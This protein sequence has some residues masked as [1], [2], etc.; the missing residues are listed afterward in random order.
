MTPTTP[1]LWPIPQEL[2]PRPDS[3][4]LGECVIVLP[5][6]ADRARAA[7][8]QLLADMVLDDYNLVVPIVRG[9]APKEKMPIRIGIAG[10][11]GVATPANLPGAEGYLLSVTA[12]G[13]EATGRD[14]RGAQYAIA[15]L[16]QLMAQE[17]NDVLVRGAE[18]RDWPYK[19]VRMVHLYLPGEDH[20]PYARRYL[21]DFLIRYKYN[22]LFV[23]I[24]GGVRLPKRPEIAAG[25]RRF[26]DDLR[27][28]GDM[29]PVYG[30]HCP[31]GP[32]GRF[33]DSIHTHL[34]DGRFLQPEDLTQLASWTRSLDLDFVPE[35]Q[36]LMH[37]FYLATA[38]PDIAELKEAAFPDSY[39]PCNPK[40]YEILFDVM[41]SYIDLTGC[42][43]V[44]IGHDE[45][46]AGGL[47]PEC[48]PRDTGELYGDD[49]VKIAQWLSARGQ[50]VWMWA[51]HLI[52]RHN[53]LGGS[54]RGGKVW[55]DHPQ[56]MKAAEIIKAGAPFIT[57]LNWSHYLG[58][59]E[60]DD[61]LTD[62][63]F[64]WIFGNFHGPSFKDWPERSAVPKALGAEVS[65]WCAWEDFEL[66]MIHYPDAV[67]C[68]N[69]LWS[70]HWP[71]INEAKQL[72]ARQMP[73]LRDRMRRSWEKP[74]LWSVAVGADRKHV[75]PIA[76]AC[77]AGPKG[78]TWD[79]SGLRTGRG[80]YEGVPYEIAAGEKVA[81]V[82]ARGHQPAG[83]YPHA[84]APIPIGGEYGSLIF[85]QASSANGAHPMHAGD[86]TNHPR[87][88]AELLGWYE[89]RFED[90]LTRAAEIRCGENVGAWDDGFRHL[91]YAREIPVGTLPDGRP[92]VLWGLEWTNPRPAVPITSVVL[93]GAK[94]LPQTRPE[95]EVSDARPMLFGI[96]AVETPRWVD[97][98]PE[99]GGRPPGL[100]NTVGA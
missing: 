81:V 58:K 85:W 16:M 6:R 99:Y 3:L 30:E 89:I 47:C 57:L 29:V 18:I 59:R 35:V 14:R 70:N 88:A 62:L 52:P 74:R 13:I 8:A 32:N 44:H 53:G 43:S 71:E 55:Y 54:H 41:A 36:S 64:R 87:E 49:V 2:T 83:A 25:W 78:E 66:G 63:G 1:S 23:E 12:K 73:L 91:Y 33:S 31:L 68:A 86:G 37:C 15:T 22:G 84:S 9:K 10:E 75:I 38:Y 50:G 98:R 60:G 65:S 77:N 28:L 95:G 69:L 97:R 39:C 100:E 93:H 4:R 51:D 67:Y 34:A 19:P 96:T 24:G 42:K 20:L 21:R 7:L 82:A 76:A 56:T 94:G 11:S 92:L 45:W 26:V 61:I 90:G 27:A 48:S 46:R 17:G 5:A 79:L 40:S 80:E 72:T